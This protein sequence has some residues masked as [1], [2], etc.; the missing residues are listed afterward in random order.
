MM[1]LTGFMQSDQMDDAV[2][3]VRNFFLEIAAVTSAK[4]GKQ[5]GAI[6]RPLISISP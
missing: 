2:Q 5:K 3:L 6:Y 4:P 1:A